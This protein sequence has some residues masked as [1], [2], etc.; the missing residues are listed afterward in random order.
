MVCSGYLC[1]VFNLYCQVSCSF[2][3]ADFYKVSA[4]NKCL[5]TT[6][7]NRDVVL[8]KKVWEHFQKTSQCCSHTFLPHCTPAY[9][10]LAITD[11]GIWKHKK[12]CTIIHT[13]S[14]DLK[15]LNLCFVSIY[16]K[17]LDSLSLVILVP[18]CFVLCHVFYCLIKV[19]LMNLV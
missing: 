19:C 17:H 4:T 3:Y 6:D 9:K 8:T 5:Q 11:V 16:C 15:P 13:V 1:S 7:V 10:W 12:H 14:T 18:C 2:L